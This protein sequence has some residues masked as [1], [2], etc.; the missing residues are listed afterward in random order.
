MNPPES[1]AIRRKAWSSTRATGA[2]L[3]PKLVFSNKRRFPFKVTIVNIGPAT[4]VADARDRRHS[5]EREAVS[6][7]Q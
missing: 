2:D 3:R 7:I 6:Q 4:T 1:W 5:L